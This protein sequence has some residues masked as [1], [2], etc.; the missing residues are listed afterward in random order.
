MIKGIKK[1]NHLTLL[2]K[3]K[4]DVVPGWDTSSLDIIRI[5]K[6]TSVVPFI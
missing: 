6:I 1:N 5:L 2:K 3:K 4:K